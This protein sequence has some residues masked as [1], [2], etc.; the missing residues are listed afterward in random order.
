MEDV[1]D[2]PQREHACEQKHD[3][4]HDD[5]AEPGIGGLADTSKHDAL[6]WSEGFNLPAE[7]GAS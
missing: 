2:A 3:R 6:L 5:A 4:T 7:G 1:I